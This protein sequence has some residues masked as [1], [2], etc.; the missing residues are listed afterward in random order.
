M[1]F[2]LQIFQ[3]AGRLQWCDQKGQYRSAWGCGW[4]NLMW[5]F[6]FELNLFLPGRVKVNS[7]VQTHLYS[8]ARGYKWY[9]L[10]LTNMNIVFALKIHHFSWQIFPPC[11]LSP[12]CW[13]LL[14]RWTVQEGGQAAWE[15]VSERIWGILFS[16]ELLCKFYSFNMVKCKWQKKSILTNCWGQREDIL[17]WEDGQ[18]SGWYSPWQKTCFILFSS[19]DLNKGAVRTQSCYS[20]A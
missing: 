14:G 8:A 18:N 13:I 2:H 20:K 6:P 17:Q 19:L 1:V 12:R 3:A 5:G 16:S 11:H 7:A 4:R 9:F 10:F 15:R